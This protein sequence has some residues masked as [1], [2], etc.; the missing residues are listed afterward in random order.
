LRRGPFTA[1]A[2]AKDVTSPHD[3]LS[4]IAIAYQWVSRIIT[5]C[6]EMVLPGLLGVWVDQKL[7]TRILFT[8]GGF[9]V[10][11]TLGIWHL[12]RMTTSGDQGGSEQGTPKR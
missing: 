11:M 10:G 6:L 7:G 9:A 4:V 8:L 12:I 2:A 5:V 3:D 1:V